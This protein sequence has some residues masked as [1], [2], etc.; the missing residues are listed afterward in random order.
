[1]FS[2]RIIGI[3]AVSDALTR[4]SYPR[5]VC[6]MRGV[7]FEPTLSGFVVLIFKISPKLSFY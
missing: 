3:T 7:G 6:K 2:N 5:G 1:M 4:L